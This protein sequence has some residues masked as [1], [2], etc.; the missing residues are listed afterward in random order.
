VLT[1]P[2]EAI[3]GILRSAQSATP[4]PRLGSVLEDFRKHWMAIGRRRYPQLQ[5]DLEDAVQTALVK[6]VSSEKLATLRDAG[7]LEAW[8]RSLFVHTV[9]DLARDGRRHSRRRTYVGAPEDDPE[10]ALRDALPD[11]APSPEELASYR[12]RLVIVARAA[13]RL[14]VARLKFVDDL[15]EKEIARRQGLTRDS[16]AGQLKRIRKALRQSF[17]DPK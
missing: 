6:L 17:E 15:P 10:H 13:S 3:L 1:G 12:E 7:R 9:L 14:E 4:D 8:A 2:P 16:V 5:N 11:V